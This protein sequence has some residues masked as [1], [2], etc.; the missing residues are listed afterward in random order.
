M[1]ESVKRPCLFGCIDSR[2]ELSHYLVCPVLW[3]LATEFL[4]GTSS[5]QVGFRLCLVEP[6]LLSLQHLAFV[7]AIYHF[8]KNDCKCVFQEWLAPS[9]IVQRRVFEAAHSIVMMI[10]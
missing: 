9:H 5:I 2:D 6:S 3:N 7:H 8:V 4:G 10:R 1:G